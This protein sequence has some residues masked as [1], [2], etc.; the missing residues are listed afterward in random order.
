MRTE[1]IKLKWKSSEQLQEIREAAERAAAAAQALAKRREGL[2]DDVDGVAEITG[3]VL[4]DNAMMAELLG[5]ALLQV[6]I[7]EERI[8]QLEEGK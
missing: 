1:L 3:A 5:T 6:S 4:E 2:V 7:L 8:L